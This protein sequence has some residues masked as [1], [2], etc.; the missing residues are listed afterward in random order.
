MRDSQDSKNDVFLRYITICVV[1][2]I[3]GSFT[4]KVNLNYIIPE[5]K[6][7]GL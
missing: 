5:L 1:D 6:E 7:E 3:E 4:Y 2:Q